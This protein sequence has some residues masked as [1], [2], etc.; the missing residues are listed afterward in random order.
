MP[1]RMLVLRLLPPGV[2]ATLLAEVRRRHPGCT[3][4]SLAA[5]DEVAAGDE[6]IDWR[7]V[8]A[9][10][11]PGLLRRSRF[12]LM[13]VAHGRD[14]CGSGAYWRAVVLAA[15]SGARSIGFSEDGG[16]PDRGLAGAV[17]AGLAWGMVRWGQAAL[18]SLLSL[19]ILLLVLGA[20]AVADLTEW[21]AE[22]GRTGGSPK[23]R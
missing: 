22:G 8:S 20:A 14:H 23:T 4:T 15:L 10:A 11:L 12:D 7:G 16:L 9:R 6:H 1:Q 18:A 21:M 13:V 17:A 2:F 19:L 3:I 5:S